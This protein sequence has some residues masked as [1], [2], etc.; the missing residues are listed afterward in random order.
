MD[1]LQRLL[2][3]VLRWA[4]QLPR[5]GPI[6][7]VLEQVMAN[8]FRVT[9]ALPPLAEGEAGEVVARKLS[10]KINDAEPIDDEFAADTP[11][12]VFEA[13]QGDNVLLSLTN[14]DDA[15]NFSAASERSFQVIDNIAPGAPGEMQVTL[16]EIPD[17]PQ[18]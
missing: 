11:T 7:I 12:A 18:P 4:S 13:N 10:R 2:H 3:Y 6:Y 5:P 9:V 1:W 15:G 8:R 17:S 16:E 14:K